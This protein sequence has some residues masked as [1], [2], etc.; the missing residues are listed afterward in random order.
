MQLRNPVEHL[1]SFKWG[2]IKMLGKYARGF[3]N[4]DKPAEDLEIDTWYL[5]HRTN[6]SSI[7]IDFVDSFWDEDK[8]HRE[9]YAHVALALNNGTLNIPVRSILI[10]DLL[11][12]HIGREYVELSRHKTRWEVF[13]LIEL[14]TWDHWLVASGK[15]V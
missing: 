11:R 15:I 8:A 3:M 1:S 13:T 9:K 2:I 4:P 5:Y 6:A 10:N 14:T 7:E 12:L